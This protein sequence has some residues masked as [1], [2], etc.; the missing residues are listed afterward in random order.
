VTNTR[1]DQ[2]SA[3]P[4]IAY[5]TIKDA[6]G[7]I[8]YV[9]VPYEDFLHLEKKEEA[10]VPNEVVERVIMGKLTPI[11][12]WREHLGMTQAEVAARM[13][14]SQAAFAQFEASTARPRPSTLR[15]VAQALGIQLEQ[16]DF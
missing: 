4:Q 10:W 13:A 16:L 3:E 11:R 6:N 5:Q 1:I 12:A 2:Q 8:Q 15:R 9:V 7:V 14:I